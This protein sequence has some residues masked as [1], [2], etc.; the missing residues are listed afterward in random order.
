MKRLG[1]FLSALAMVLLMGCNEPIPPQVPENDIL[2]IGEDGVVTEYLVEDFAQAYYSVEELATMAKAEATAY[3]T[4]HQAA[5]A[6]LVT[7]D[8]VEEFTT[9][10]VKRVRM[11]TVYASANT[12]AD[13]SEQV[14]FFGTGAEAAYLLAAD[15]ATTYAENQVIVTN[16]P[17]VIYPYKQVEAVVASG[18]YT[19]LEDGGVDLTQ[20]DRDGK[21]VIILKK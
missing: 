13:Y 5:G 14:L 1:I 21:T 17:S 8:A 20:A 10:S 19:I 3:N 12:F 2:I 15:L 11:K 6:A 4:L 9:A 7:V 18:A 16:V